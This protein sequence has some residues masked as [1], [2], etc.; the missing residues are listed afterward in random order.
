MIM[1]KEGKKKLFI[2]FF[3]LCVF[4]YP[5]YF[6]PFKFFFN[7]CCAVI[8]LFCNKR[9]KMKN[10]NESEFSMWRT[11]IGG[12]NCPLFAMKMT[13]KNVKFSL[14][15]SVWFLKLIW[16]KFYQLEPIYISVWGIIHRSPQN[17]VTF[18]SFVELWRQIWL[19]DIALAQSWINSIRKHIKIKP[20]NI[21]F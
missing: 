16:Y 4:F 13:R 2:L 3:F 17:N 11:N 9:K 21:H 10:K 1:R 12:W 6:C 15:W 5:L 20:L 8:A 19:W 14:Q 7:F 18:W